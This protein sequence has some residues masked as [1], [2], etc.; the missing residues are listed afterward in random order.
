MLIATFFRA[1]AKD[2]CAGSQCVLKAS[3]EVEKFAFRYLSKALVGSLYEEL[4]KTL[5]LVA[6]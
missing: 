2:L 4:R 3:T 6:R 1:F 5:Q